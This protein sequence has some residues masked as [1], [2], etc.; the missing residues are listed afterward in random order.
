MVAKGDDD[1]PMTVPELILQSEEEVRRFIECMRMKEIK[2]AVKEKMDDARS[3]IEVEN[4]QRILK[5]E[6]CVIQYTPEQV[7]II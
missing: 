2:L 6:R 5:D 4:A 3:R 7:K 1:K